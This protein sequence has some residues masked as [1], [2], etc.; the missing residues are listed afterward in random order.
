MISTVTEWIDGRESKGSPSRITRQIDCLSLKLVYDTTGE[1]NSLQQHG[2][3]ISILNQDANTM[4]II[5]DD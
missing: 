5:Q 3:V 4:Q 2:L 1:R